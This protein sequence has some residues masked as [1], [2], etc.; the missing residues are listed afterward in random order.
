[1]LFGSSVASLPVTAADQ[2][3]KPVS[4][5]S[6]VAE[7]EALLRE[8]EEIWDSQ[9]T[10]RLKA[11]WDTDDNAPYYLAG[12]QEDWFV[13]WDELNRYLDPPPGTPKVTQAIRVRFY[14]IRARLLAP[15]LAFAAYWMRTDMKLVFSPQPFGSDNRVA[16]V[17]RK[18]PEGWRYLC[19]AEAFQTPNMYI[20]KLYE[21][22]ISPE[23]QEFFDQV[24]KKP[25]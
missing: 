5:D 9:D 22:N 23:Y 21:K 12:E 4:P 19:Y 24:T 2:I 20:Q 14:N 11:L 1:M 16:S 6:L 10:S 7:I 13:G 18:R 8:T 17:F 15:D 25:G 3:L